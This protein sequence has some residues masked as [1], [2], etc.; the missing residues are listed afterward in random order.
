MFVVAACVEIFHSQIDIRC[1]FEIP[2]SS[3]WNLHKN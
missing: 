1:A 3:D 2:R